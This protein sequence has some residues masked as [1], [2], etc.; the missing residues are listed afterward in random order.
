MIGPLEVCLIAVIVLLFFTPSKL[1][2]LARAIGEAFREFKSV[3]PDIEKF[4]VSVAKELGIETE[5][6]SVKQI[7]DEVR[8]RVQSLGTTK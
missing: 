3:K 2:P 7:A 8:R 5:D 1:P 6:K 4:I